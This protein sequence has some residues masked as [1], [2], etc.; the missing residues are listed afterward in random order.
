MYDAKDLYVQRGA[1]IFSMQGMSCEIVCVL[2]Y[3]SELRFLWNVSVYKNVCNTSTVFKGAL[4]DL[5][6]CIL[7]CTQ[8]S[9]PYFCVLYFIS[10]I[11]RIV[12]AHLCLVGYSVTLPRY[13][14]CCRCSVQVHMAAV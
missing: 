10:F 2:Q 6:L 14:S 8:R 5:A 9:L 12:L 3:P 13:L 11:P 1:A 7:F 4:C